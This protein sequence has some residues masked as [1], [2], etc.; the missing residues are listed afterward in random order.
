KI[1]K[2]IKLLALPLLALML[3][4]GCTNYEPKTYGPVE[5][6]ITLEGPFFKDGVTDGMTIVS[7]KPE[8]FGISRDEIF[9]MKVNKITLETDSEGGLG[10]FEN[11]VFSVMTDDTETKE[12]ASVKVKGNPKSLVIKGL[13]EA[14]IEGFKN[15]KKFYFEVTGIT[16]EDS[17]DDMKLKG[18]I[19]MD[20]MIPEK[21]K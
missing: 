6:E 3:L 13:K 19:K 7:F 5:F 14:E 4:Y 12:V 8:D 17:F 2:K 9:S 18:T 15:I 11:L 1:M 20:I 16:K 21:K 10:V